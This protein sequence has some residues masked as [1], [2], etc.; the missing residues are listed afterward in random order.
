M[1]AFKVEAERCL[2]RPSWRKESTDPILHLRGCS[3]RE[4]HQATNSRH[5]K[6]YSRL[7]ENTGGGS[8]DL[9]TGVRFCPA[10]EKEGPSSG[11]FKREGPSACALR[12]RSGWANKAKPSGPVLQCVCNEAHWGKYI[13]VQVPWLPVCLC[14][15]AE[16]GLSL[17][18]PQRTIGGFLGGEQFYL[19]WPN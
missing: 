7:I 17:G 16:G 15:H 5:F 18:I 19:C 9:G 6:V 8:R 13:L 3:L 2:S 14:I 4:E 1:Y 10:P 11:E 12:T